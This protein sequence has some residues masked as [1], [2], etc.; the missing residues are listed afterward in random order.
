ML[1]VGGE[2]AFHVFAGLGH[3]RLAI[4]ALP[5]PLAVR[6]TLLDGPLAGMPIVT[7]GGSSG[8]HDRLVGL[9][10]GGRP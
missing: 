8:S 10:G 5:A 3:P 2:T 1:L 7:K 9:V 6:A 4:D